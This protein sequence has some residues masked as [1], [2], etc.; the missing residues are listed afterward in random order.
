M[1][2]TIGLPPAVLSF[3]PSNLLRF[4]GPWSIP[5]EIRTTVLIVP[6]LFVALSWGTDSEL[7]YVGLA[8]LLYVLIF[9]HELG[10]AFACRVVGAPVERIIIHPLGGL[11]VFE[12]RDLSIDDVAFVVAMGPAVNLA[13][14]ASASLLAAQ[15]W[16]A[17]AAGFLEWVALL[18]LLLAVLNL[19]PTLPADGGQIFRLWLL[20]FLPE[21][22]ANRIS[23]GV[24]LALL[25]LWFPAFMFTAVLF[26]FLLLYW[27]P[28]RLHWRMLRHGD[29]GPPYSPVKTRAWHLWRRPKGPWDLPVPK[30]IPAE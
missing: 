21:R 20:G 28:V 24:G 9:L 17:P 11:C 7:L 30:T 23:G 13:L 6:V 15:P 5:V 27:V 10:H 2:F 1:L 8:L 16:A 3:T 19:V 12:P 22:L 4:R 25:F 14:W 26:H 18:N 29:V